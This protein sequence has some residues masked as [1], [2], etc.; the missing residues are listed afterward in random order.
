M[1]AVFCLLCWIVCFVGFEF[2]LL[3]GG[4]WFAVGFFV[5][6]VFCVWFAWACEF[7]GGAFVLVGLCVSGCWYCGCSVGLHFIVALVLV[8]LCRLGLGFFFDG[9]ECFFGWI[10]VAYYFFFF[11]ELYF[12]S[13]CCVLVLDFICLGGLFVLCFWSCAFFI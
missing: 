8:V 6:C 11:L 2:F 12:F 9:Q 7:L 13:G 4:V 10:V 5:G 1:V 3:L